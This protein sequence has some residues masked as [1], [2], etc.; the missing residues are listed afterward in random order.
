[1]YL[2]NLQRRSLICIK[3]QQSTDISRIPRKYFP[4]LHHVYGT[5]FFKPIDFFHK[6][7]E[8]N[9]Y[10]ALS[11][12]CIVRVLLS[13]KRIFLVVDLTNF[14]FFLPFKATESFRYQRQMRLFYPFTTQ[15]KQKEKKKSMH[16]MVSVTLLFNLNFCS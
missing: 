1:M 9:C 12:E 4:F 13:N 3:V 14:L 6:D 8:W 10:T 16:C 7:A 15:Q 11:T 5:I 2:C